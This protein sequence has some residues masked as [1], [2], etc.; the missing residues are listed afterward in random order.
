MR[1]IIPINQNWQFTKEGR[2]QTITL[3]HSWNAIDGQDGGDDYYRGTCV[4]ERALNCQ[5]EDG[6]RVYLEV[7]GASSE[8]AVYL[9]GHFVG[10]HQ[11]GYSTFRFDLTP[12]WAA[13]NNLRIQV[14]NAPNETVYPQ[15]A[16]FTFYGGLYRDVNLVEVPAAHFAMEPDGTP[17]LFVRAEVRGTDAVVTAA[18]QTEGGSEVRF[19]LGPEQVTVQP[20]NGRA[21]ASVT[22]HNAHLWQGREDP[23][24]YHA[25]AEL[26]C[27]GQVVDKLDT[28][29]GCRSFSVD[30]QQGFILNGTPY[31]LRGV[32]RH[33]DWRGAG[34]A[35]TREMMD[36]D[37]DILLELGATSVRLAHY[38]HHQYFYDLCDRKGI[39]V[40][41]EIPYITK[42]MPGGN[43]NA[44]QQM[45]ELITQCQNHPSIICWALSNEICVAGLTNDL[46]QNHKALHELVHRLDPSRP[47]AIADAFMLEPGSPINDIPDLLAYNL[48]FGW[49]SGELEDNDSFFDEFHEKYPNRCVGLAE[50]GADCRFDLESENPQRGDYSEQYQCLYHEH[51]LRMIQARP[52]LWCTYVWN[53]FDFGAD[54][55]EEADDPGV[56][57]K[58][59]VTFDRKVKKDAYYLYKAYWSKEAFVYLCGRRFVERSDSVTTVKAY[60]NL[61]HVSFYCDGTLVEEQTGGPVYTLR[62]PITG[63]HQVEVRAENCTDTITIRKVEEKNKTYFL[64]SASV[65]NWFDDPGMDSIPGFYSVQDKM[66]DIRQDSTGRALIDELIAVARASRGSVTKE[67]K[68]TE[69]M[70]QMLYRS[71]VLGL[72]HQAG[73]AITQEMALELNQKLRQIPK[74]DK[75]GTSVI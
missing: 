66:E 42:H 20:V 69:A 13:E 45:R 61:R 47:T 27:A 16:D 74:P 11:G 19:I 26:L 44:V 5:L 35:L 33:Q 8:A 39:L 10:E 2:T 37:M 50:Y 28:Q 31:P 32:S 30:P 7:N 43:T 75:S 67:V 40:W 22:I 72:I 15:K 3:P 48:Y 23:F 38:Q 56:N 65:Q 68:R 70:E 53:L 4:Y 57:H 9:N 24:L 18:A 34:N 41:A 49:Y 17:G 58:G 36:A 59:L 52:W 6:Q 63:E 55:R 60:S 62:L 46:L 14:S 25:S 1:R 64:A 71:T 51:L 54:G 29:F 21:E 12:Y 73:G